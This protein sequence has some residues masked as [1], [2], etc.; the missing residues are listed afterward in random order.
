MTITLFF[1]LCV[2][3]QT[4]AAAPPQP[5]VHVPQSAP[6]PQSAQSHPAGEPEAAGWTSLDRVVIVVND[7]IVTSKQLEGRY[8]FALRNGFERPKSRAEQA[9][10]VNALA[11]DAVRTRLKAQAGEALGFDPAQVERIQKNDL[12]R[13]IKARGGVVGFSEFLASRQVTAE[14]YRQVRRDFIYTEL[15]EDAITG[16]GASVSSRPSSDRFVRPGLLHFEY[17]NAQLDPEFLTEI[18]GRPEIVHFRWLVLFESDTRPLAGVQA[19]AQQLRAQAVDGSDMEGLVQTYSA[20]Q[21][22][23]MDATIPLT[24][25]IRVF[26]QATSF[27]TQAK[28]GDVS[29]VLPFR[30]QGARGFALFRLEER[31]AGEV[32]ALDE[33][34]VQQKLT[35]RLQSEFDQQRIGVALKRAFASS[36]VWKYGENGA[37]VV[38]PNAAAKDAAPAAPVTPAA[39]PKADEQVAPTAPDDVAPTAPVTPPAEAKTDEPIGPPAPNEAAPAE[40]PA[41]PEDSAPPDDSMPPDDSARTEPATPPRDSPR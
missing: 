14:D 13:A 20:I 15:W 28:P 10:F 41:P 34:A 11:E 21:G 35:K 8:S 16:A 40:K 3:L 1:A 27:F 32:P 12:E 2:A 23:D 9:E 38:E 36:Y 4:P 31:T 19:L 22:K 18:G 24:Q 26:P 37:P 33:F 5:P 7:D 17:K 6:V 30:N 25:A 39:D 29:D